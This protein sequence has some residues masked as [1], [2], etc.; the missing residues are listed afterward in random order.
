MTVVDRNGEGFRRSIAGT[1]V[2]QRAVGDVVGPSCCA[3]RGARAFAHR[4]NRQRAAQRVA[5]CRR[6]AGRVHVDQ[7][8]V[9]EC[10][11]T[12]VRERRIRIVF[13]RRADRIGARHRNRRP[14]IGAGDGHRHHLADQAAVTIVDRDGEIFGHTLAGGQVLRRRVVQRVGPAHRTRL[15]RRELAHA[16]QREGAERRGVTRRR[17]EARA[18]GVDQVDVVERDRACRAQRVGGTRRRRRVF[19]YRAALHAASDRRPVV[20]A[21]D[22]HGYRLADRAAVAI[23]DRDDEIFGC[24]LARRQVLRRRVVQRVGP[25]DRTVGRIG[26]LVDRRQ[27]KRSER[28]AVARRRREDRAVGVG[29]V[30]IVE[31]HR[32]RCGQRVACTRRCGRILGHHTALRGARD[33]HA[34]IR[35][36]DPHGRR[37]PAERAVGEPDGIGESVRE[38]FAGRQA[39]ELG[40]DGGAERAGVVTNPTIRGNPDLCSH[41]TAVVAEALRSRRV[42][43]QE[44][45]RRI[46][47]GGSRYAGSIIER[48]ECLRVAA[49]I[50]PHH[51]EVLDAKRILGE[52]RIRE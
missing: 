26:R 39:L 36:T 6:N 46:D 52:A 47:L 12:A 24:G 50:V 8:D 11:R 29:Q 22:G 40:H 35:A 18:V 43:S 34:I 10:D 25:A 21:G 7:V 16:A 31:R 2:L 15:G 14:I 19:G 17:R 41:R 28:G 45:C 48:P 33:R 13:A 38:V 49:Q 51:I 23:T 32:A 5:G 9:V 27:R 44:V 4:T 20:G 30:D 3:G 1:E 42:L 37:G